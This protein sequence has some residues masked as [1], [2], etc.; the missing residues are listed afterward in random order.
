MTTLLIHEQA[1]RRIETEIVAVEED[2]DIVL[3]DADG[4]LQSK[5]IEVDI[6]S[7]KPDVAWISIDPMLTGQLEQYVQLVLESGT[8]KWLQTFHA[9]LD[10]GFYAD[11]FGKGLRIA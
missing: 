9:G 11:L 3:M 4:I 8:V 7:A 5:G 2:L 6:Q 10:F 1:Y